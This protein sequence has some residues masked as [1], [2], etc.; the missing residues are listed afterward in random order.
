MTVIELHDMNKVGEVVMFYDVLLPSTFQA[1]LDHTLMLLTHTPVIFDDRQTYCHFQVKFSH[2]P[3][4]D[5]VLTNIILNFI[6]V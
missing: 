3:Q 4:Y 6:T 5:G 2:P 1:L